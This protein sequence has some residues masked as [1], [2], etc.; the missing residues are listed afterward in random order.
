MQYIKSSGLD[1]A[2]IRKRLDQELWEDK[3]FGE[4]ERSIF[5]GTVFRLTPSGK[6]YQPFANS[7]VDACPHCKGK[8]EIKKKGNA[9]RLKYWE[10][11]RKKM[12]AKFHRGIATK[13]K[14][15]M[16]YNNRVRCEPTKTCP[17]C[18]GMGSIEALKDEQWQECLEAE[19]DELGLYSFSGEGDP[20]DIFVGESR[21]I[22]EDE[23]EDDE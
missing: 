8:C 15:N 17:F 12:E 22:D 3:D 1:M 7:N 16:I 13:E 4:Q 14:L 2:D 5:I 9:R 19:L 21:E 23:S 20:C 6:Y 18:E 11:Q 10:N